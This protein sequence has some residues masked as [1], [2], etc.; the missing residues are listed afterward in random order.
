MEVRYID[1]DTEEVVEQS[2]VNGLFSCHS[3]SAF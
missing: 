3:G 2:M 1:T